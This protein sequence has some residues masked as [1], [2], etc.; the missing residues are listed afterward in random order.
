MSGESFTTNIIQWQGHDMA[1]AEKKP[2]K[3]IAFQIYF[4]WRIYIEKLSPEQLKR[5]MI[6]TFDFAEHGTETDMSDDLVLEIA[7]TQMS[8]QIRRDTEKYLKE[9]EKNA[10]NGA[11][12][13]RPSKNPDKPNGFSESERFSDKPKKADKDKVKEDVKEENKENVNSKYEVKEDTA[14]ADS[15]IPTTDLI[16]SELKTVYY[17]TDSEA[18]DVSE[19]FYD[20]NA[21]RDWSS[22][23]TRSWQSLLKQFVGNDRRFTDDILSERKDKAEREAEEERLRVEEEAKHWQGDTC[24]PTGQD[25]VEYLKGHKYTTYDEEIATDL[26]WMSEYVETE[27]GY[28]H[29]DNA[30]TEAELIEMFESGIITVDIQIGVTEL[31]HE[32]DIAICQDN[33]LVAKIRKQQESYKPS[34]KPPKPEPFIPNPTA[35]D[36]LQ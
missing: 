18:A 6:A 35:F 13:G 33:A 24:F 15:D 31:F 26:Y 8:N 34:F 20:F 25:F 27:Y 11:K 3:R 5:L 29:D 30:F 16:F 1:Q 12:G 2:K 14:V 7:F 9:C 10:Q 19:S 23:E 32:P 22:L 36:D 17:L 4:E 28:D 21:K